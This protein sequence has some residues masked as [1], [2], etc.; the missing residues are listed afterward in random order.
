MLRKY[1]THLAPATPDQI[2]RR[3]DV[4]AVLGPFAQMVQEQTYRLDEQVTLSGANFSQKMQMPDSL[5]AQLSSACQKAIE[6]STSPQ[7]QELLKATSSYQARETLILLLSGLPIERIA[8]PPE[9]EDRAPTSVDFRTNYNILTGISLAVF[10]HRFRDPETFRRMMVVTPK[11]YENEASFDTTEELRWHSDGYA[12]RNAGDIA[13]HTIL[14]GINGDDKIHTRFLSAAHIF[15]NIDEKYKNILLGKNFYF[16]EETD[17]GPLHHDPFSI[18]NKDS[19]G[20]IGIRYGQLGNIEGKTIE[21]KE[22]LKH[23]AEVIEKVQESATSITIST[24]DICTLNNRL[25]LHSRTITPPESIKGHYRRLIARKEAAYE[26]ES[27]EI[28]R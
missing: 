5:S 17:F 23:L 28:S 6:Q 8:L 25:L 26:G 13:G 12:A 24:G 19:H 9:L 2:L 15:N 27:A 20:V 4:S 1:F 3:V 16:V 14:L 10:G 11:K 18:F 21:E 7:K 22:A